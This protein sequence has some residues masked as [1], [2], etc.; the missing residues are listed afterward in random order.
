MGVCVCVC[1]CLRSQTYPGKRLGVIVW[2]GSIVVFPFE[3]NLWV[4]K[5]KGI[6]EK[7]KEIEEIQIKFIYRACIDFALYWLP[8]PN[9]DKST[10][11]AE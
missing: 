10:S 2:S 11:G 8:T 3:I 7:K 6:E 4:K 5:K 9:S 1:V